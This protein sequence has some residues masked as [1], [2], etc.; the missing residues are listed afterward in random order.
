MNPV[1]QYLNATV[2]LL[3]SA[4]GGPM[5]GDYYC[6]EDFVLQNGIDFGA[7]MPHRFKM[8]RAGYCYANA[9]RLSAR[10]GLIYC[11]GYALGIIPVMH[12]WCV[13]RDGNVIDNT[14]RTGVSY[15]GIAI[16]RTYVAKAL[17]RQKTY[18]IIDQ[19]TLRWPILREN[20]S[21]WKESLIYERF[22]KP[23]SPLVARP[24]RGQDGAHC[25]SALP[26]S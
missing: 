15:Y 24:V 5:V 20:P 21:D 19:Y 8:G 16:K 11:E 12:A 22:T 23:I 9:S 3:R 6:L 17:L 7:R 18:G 14:W 1:E 4:A 2:S 26:E 13:D 10:A 25:L